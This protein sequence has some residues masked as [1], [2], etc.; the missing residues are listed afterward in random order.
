MG[1]YVSIC[2]NH[3]KW[4]ANEQNIF[5]LQ[6]TLEK[7][8]LKRSKRKNPHRPKHRTISNP[9]NNHQRKL[10]QRRQIQSLLALV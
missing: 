9:S 6:N 5:V 2:R 7:R 10:R 8:H 3:E 4:N 1:L